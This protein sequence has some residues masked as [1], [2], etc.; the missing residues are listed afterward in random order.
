MI[1]IAFAC[2]GCGVPVEGRLE[3]NTGGMTCAKCGRVTPLPE[4]GAIAAEGHV[5]ACTVC[6][7]T[8]LYAQRDFNRKL[9]LAIVAVGLGLGP[10]TSWI[11]VGVAVV[12]DAALYR[13]RAVG[14]DLLRLQRPV[15]RAREGGVA[16][17]VRH[18][19]PRRLQVRQALPPRRDVAVAGP[20]A[21]RL[22]L[23]GKTP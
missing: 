10:F 22:R 16:G 15:P 11:S 14:G 3:G 7:S 6:G 8:D 9:G 1:E 17:R 2:P 4:A 18:R 13:A 20:L 23:E 19:D 12:L 5:A 21:T